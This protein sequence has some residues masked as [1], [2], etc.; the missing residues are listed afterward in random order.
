MPPTSSV[1]ATWELGIRLRE[2]REEAG[3]KGIAAAKELG[4]SQNF[5]SD[6]ENGKKRLSSEKLLTAAELY[7]VPKPDW[8]ELVRLRD[9]TER[10]GWWSTQSGLYPTELMRYFGFEWGADSIRT[11][12]SLL[13]PGLLQTEAYAHAVMTSDSPNIRT[14]EAHQRVRHRLMRQNRLCDDEPLQL[15]A[16]LNEAALLQE[17]G[18]RAVLADQLRHLREMAEQ[19][20][21]IEIYVVPFSAGAYATLGQGTMHILEFSSPRLPLLAWYENLTSYGLVDNQVRLREYDASYRESLQKALDRE[22][23]LERVQ[24]AIR[25]L[26]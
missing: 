12:E 13:I 20:P 16:V 3:L 23:S 15:T 25:A 18:G 22:E 17:V 19:H 1:V 10:R 26:K 24:Q 11:Q 2:A 7:D 21:T 5:L 9:E 8:E 14:S 4:L 6:V